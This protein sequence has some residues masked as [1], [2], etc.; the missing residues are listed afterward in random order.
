MRG[1]NDINDKLKPHFALGTRDTI[2]FEVNQECKSV[3]CAGDCNIFDRPC[4]FVR[5]FFMSRVPNLLEPVIRW[6]HRLD[7]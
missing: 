2:E 4:L 7:E 1:N 6:R 3:E 5:H